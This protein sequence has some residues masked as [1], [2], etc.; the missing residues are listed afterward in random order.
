MKIDGQNLL[1]MIATNKGKDN[2]TARDAF[3]QF[4]GYYEHKVMQ[5]AI[6]MCNK[7]GKPEGYAINIV[8]C[9]FQKVWLYPT[10]DIS[11]SKIKDTDRAILNWISR[12]LAHELSLFS[13][14][15]NCSHPEPEDL[16]LITSTA[17]FL[18]ESSKYL[19]LSEEMF[20]AAKR[21]L[22]DAING[23]NEKD[24]IIYLTYKLYLCFGKTVPRNVLKKLRTQLNMGQ[25]AIR[26][27][28]FRLSNIIEG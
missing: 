3:E 20:E 21:K 17:V 13:D 28:H 26:Q 18:Q 12:I 1:S 22:D 7:W 23:L 19:N 6:I 24:R 25:E 14:K 9:A 15:G 11:K 10:F 4:C 5:M 27:R 8:Q 16:P 2:K